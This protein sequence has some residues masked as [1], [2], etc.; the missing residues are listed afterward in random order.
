MPL[1]AQAPNPTS[2]SNAFFGSVTARPAT[3]EIL[4][5]SLNEAIALGLQNNLGLKEAENGE[6]S[7]QG[8]KN[9]ALQM[10][11]PTIALTGDLG[12]HQQNLA[13]LGFGPDT[14]KEFLKLFPGGKLP[15]GF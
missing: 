6:K 11:L 13:A 14:I 2:A 9:E 3:D 1:H 4:K 15:A 10:F 5:L 7:L 8:Q 12:V